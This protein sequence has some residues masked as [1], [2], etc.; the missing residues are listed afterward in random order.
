MRTPE[1]PKSAP[2]SLPPEVMAYSAP[3]QQ[4]SPY[5]SF[6]ARVGAWFID[7]VVLGCVRLLM[8]FALGLFFIL[9]EGTEIDRILDEWASALILLALYLV[10]YPYF[11]LLEASPWQ[12]TVGKLAMGIR[13]EDIDGGRATFIQTS[14]RFFGRIASALILGIGFLC[15]LFTGRRQALHDIGANTIVTQRPPRAWAPHPGLMPPYSPPPTS[16]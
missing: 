7:G 12:A 3:A 9:V 14:A 13:V 1:T 6:G 4:S 8:F 10:A 5:A 16:H 11:A 2:P 15:P